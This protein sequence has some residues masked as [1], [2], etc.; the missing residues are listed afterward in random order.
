MYVLPTLLAETKI[1][2]FWTLIVSVWKSGLGMIDLDR[3]RGNVVGARPASLHRLVF[4]RSVEE[5]SVGMGAQHDV[6]AVCRRGGVEGDL[7]FSLLAK[8]DAV[9]F[10]S[11]L[12]RTG[13]S[14]T[15]EAWARGL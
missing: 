2:F 3:Y 7:E 13:Y 15:S 4:L 9:S 1:V 14:G 5:F 8:H 10:I 11:A 12:R 6:G